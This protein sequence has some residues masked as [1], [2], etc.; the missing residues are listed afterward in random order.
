MTMAEDLLESRILEERLAKVL[1]RQQPINL[2]DLDL[3]PY[4]FRS[5]YSVRE[6]KF[7]P[8]Y[9]IFSTEIKEATR[10]VCDALGSLNFNL[11]TPLFEAILNA[12]QHG[13]KKNPGK[14]VTV[15]YKRSESSV[16]ASVLDQ[17]G[18]INPAFFPFVSLNR[19]VAGKE[20]LN[21]YD[22]CGISPIGPNLGTGTS[23]LHTYLDRISYYRSK[24]GG[25]VVHLVKNLK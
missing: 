7:S 12:H 8:D 19:R 13:N 15:A 16:E 21:F 22:V 1:A 10:E 2:A 6:F 18:E 23:F 5:G 3:E 20:A 24:E 4:E 9:N 25:L 11:F 17:G 14:S